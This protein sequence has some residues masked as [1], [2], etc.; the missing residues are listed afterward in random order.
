MSDAR[1]P[2][3]RRTSPDPSLVSVSTVTEYT[4][5][6]DPLSPRVGPGPRPPRGPF[7][8]DDDGLNSYPLWITN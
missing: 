8:S 3:S 4:Y 7:P 2:R 6:L 1:E 5:T